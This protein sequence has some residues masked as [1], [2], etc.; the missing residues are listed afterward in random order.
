MLRSAKLPNGSIVNFNGHTNDM[1]PAWPEGDPPPTVEQTR[2]Y[3]TAFKRAQRGSQLHVF[4]LNEMLAIVPEMS[5]ADLMA[6][7]IE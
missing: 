3:G 1:C 7:L 4:A 5:K 6:Y 2:A